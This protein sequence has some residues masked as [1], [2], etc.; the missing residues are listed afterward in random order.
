LLSNGDEIAVTS[1]NREK[2]V[3]L[4]AQW[5]LRGSVEKQLDAFRRGF[6]LVAGSDVVMKL[7]TIDELETLL[8]GD[9]DQ[10]YDFAEL[11]KVF[12]IFVSF[13][14]CCAPYQLYHY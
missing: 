9:T 4:Y 11:K 2:F 3:E 5:L 6:Q 10:L 7:L 8:C 12:L 14:C 13:C 1:R